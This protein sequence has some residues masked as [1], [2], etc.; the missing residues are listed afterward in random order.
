M[1]AIRVSERCMERVTVVERFIIVSIMIVENSIFIWW[2]FRIEGSGNLQ[3][4]LRECQIYITAIR[5]SK[6]CMERVTMVE[7]FIIVT[8]MIMQ[9]SIFIWCLFPIEGSG[10]LQCPLRRSQK[11]N[12]YHSNKSEQD[13]YSKSYCGGKVHHSD[14][15]HCAKYHFHLLIIS[16]RRFRQ[17]TM[18]SSE[19]PKEKSVSRQ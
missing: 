15:N 16:N 3:S 17:L 10:N 13:M 8:T 5:V 11:Q 19:E 6:R 1:T 18:S 2:L 12:L 7:R 14:F 9:N 4:P